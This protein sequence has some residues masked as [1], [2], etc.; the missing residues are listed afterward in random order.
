MSHSSIPTSLRKIPNRAAGEAG[1]TSLIS[2]YPLLTL[3]M[4][5]CVVYN[6]ALINEGAADSF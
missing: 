5:S 2:T 3:S 1:K 6:V 4:E